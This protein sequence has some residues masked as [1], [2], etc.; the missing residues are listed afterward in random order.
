MLWQPKSSERPTKSSTSP[1]QNADERQPP[2]P[3]KR[4][5]EVL[6]RAED[7]MLSAFASQHILCAASDQHHAEIGKLSQ[8][9]MCTREKARAQNMM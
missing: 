5:P 9:Y 7:P 6:A 4:L 1:Q 3:S 2:E 8:L